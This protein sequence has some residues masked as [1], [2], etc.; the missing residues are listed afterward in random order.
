M[1][2]P[3][4]AQAAG[5]NAETVGHCEDSKSDLDVPIGSRRFPVSNLKKLVRVVDEIEGLAVYKH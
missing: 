5:H 2:S 3:S 1:G 4:I